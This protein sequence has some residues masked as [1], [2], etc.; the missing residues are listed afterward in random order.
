MSDAAIRPARASRRTLVVTA[1][2]AERDAVLHGHHP[3]IGMVDGI[4][5]HRAL[6]G[7]G[8]LDVIAGGVGPIAAAVSTSCVLRHGY[9]LVI[10]AGIAGGFPGVPL[11][12]LVV[13]A[14]VVH[15]DLGADGPDG[16]DGFQSMADLGWGAVRHELDRTLVDEVAGLTGARCG[17]ILTV[18]TVTGTSER[19]EQLR[20][21]T[22]DAVAEAM[23]GAGV[24]RAA[25]QLNVPF[26]ELRS[27]SN[28]VGPRERDGWRMTEALTCLSG[29]FGALL[30]QP[31]PSS[32]SWRD[33]IGLP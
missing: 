24:H 32:P 17:A 10:S 6:T 1:A 7:A 9:D 26:L 14:A 5:V 16:P 4:E 20:R 31:L 22:P 21:R 19:A 29:A 23:E 18:S 3:A 2:P 27:I 13:A 12:S 28:R 11:E 30:A 25:S 8:M 33:E 15:A